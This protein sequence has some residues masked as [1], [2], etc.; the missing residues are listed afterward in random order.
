MKNYL[1]ELNKAFESR[2]RLGIM[3][4][5]M[6]ND[7]ITFNALKELLD[8]TDGNLAGHTRALE[9]A[10]YLRVEKSFIGKK[11]NTRFFITPEGRQAFEQHLEAL[12]KII[13]EV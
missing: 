6:V 8:L 12:E 9:Q 13:R 2:A 11:P 7:S 5:L 4:S 10:G 1:Q 3:S